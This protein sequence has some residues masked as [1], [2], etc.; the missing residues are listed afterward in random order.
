M[1]KDALWLALKELQF[2]KLQLGASILVTIFF[3]GIS[4]LSL[5]QSIMNVMDTESM[6]DRFFFIDFMFIV[7]TPALATIFMSGPYLNYKAIKDD[8]FNKRMAVYRSLPIPIKVLALSRTILMLITLFLLSIVF[9]STITYSLADLLFNYFTINDYLI[10]IVIWLGYALALGGFHTYLE[11]GT[12]GKVL[13]LFPYL[14]FVILV[15]AFYF[16]YSIIEKGIVELTISLS[17]HIGWPIAF[18]FL[19]IGMVGCVLWHALLT[20][21]LSTKDYL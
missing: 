17:I 16:Y 21:R 4:S 9:Y 18:L 10:F 14:L 3:G 2:N 19:F 7:I 13:H 15:F 5:E 12:S 20:K 6:N 8:P 11:Y 1:L